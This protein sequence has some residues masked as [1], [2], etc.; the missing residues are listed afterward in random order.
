MNERDINEKKKKKIEKKTKW[1]RK[2]DLNKG[3]INEETEKMVKMKGD[4][5]K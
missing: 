4:Y 1:R 2:W 3:K 5:K